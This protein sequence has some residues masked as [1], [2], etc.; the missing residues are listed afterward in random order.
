MKYAI[1]GDIHANI[2]ALQ[3]VLHKCRE[4]GVDKYLCIGDLVGYNASPRECVELVRSM[5]M[6][7]V[8]KG[9][10]DEQATAGTRLAGFNP[11]AAMAI[12]WTRQQLTDDQCGWLSAL[13]MLKNLGAKMTVV[14]ATLDMPEKWGYIFDPLT[15][16]A[17]LHYQFTQLCFFGHTHVPLAFDKF[18]D[19][20]GGPFEEVRIQAGHKYMINCG[21][22]GQPRDGDPRASFITYAPDENLVRLY[23]VEYDIAST[24]QRIRQAGLPERL[25]QRL[26]LGR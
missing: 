14:H 10:H 21:S 15:A 4:L 1:L 22:V 17:S 25:W 2:E 18:G 8:L 16:A 5:N 3:A 19:V 11:Q 7:V 26:A 12:E 13:P 20:K 6:E 23:R 9:N 24:Q